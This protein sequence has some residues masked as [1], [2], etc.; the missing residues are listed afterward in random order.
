MFAYKKYSNDITVKK[1]SNGIT[2]EKNSNFNNMK[3][4]LTNT[5]KQ[6]FIWK[7]KIINYSI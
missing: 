3:L 2:V 4:A 7:Q 6:N 5:R 1:Y